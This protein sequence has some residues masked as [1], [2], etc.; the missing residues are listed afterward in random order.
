M[1]TMRTHGR[2]VGVRATLAL[3]VTMTRAPSSAPAHSVYRGSH[4]HARMSS[5]SAYPCGGG[6]R[7]EAGHGWREFELNLHGIRALN[8]KTVTSGSAASWSAGCRSMTATRT[9]IGTAAC[10]PCRR[11][12]G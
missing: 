2:L 5:T 7:Y 6:A 4:L 9:S 8:G 12:T 10:R 3:T 1:T 11:G